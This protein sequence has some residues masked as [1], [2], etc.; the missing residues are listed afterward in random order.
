MKNKLN[1]QYFGGKNNQLAEKWSPSFRQLNSTFK[2]VVC[3]QSCPA[4]ISI[5]STAHHIVAWDDPR[6]AG[7]RRILE[8]AGLDSGDNQQI[9]DVDSDE[10]ANGVF[11]TKN[12]QIEEK[13]IPPMLKN[14]VKHTKI[15][16]NKYYREVE[17]RLTEVDGEG[18]KT[19]IGGLRDIA[20]ELTAGTFPYK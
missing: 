5:Q 12:A 8:N 3:V 6:A 7:A 4:L 10:A 9:G 1:E 18:R 17:R 14:S 16:T 2:G 20:D 15:H 19:V 11:L 13:D